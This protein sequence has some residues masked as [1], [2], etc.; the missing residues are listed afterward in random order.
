MGVYIKGMEMPK[1]GEL[2]CINIHP[3]GKVCINLDLECEKVGEA[4][5][6]PEHGRLI[7]ADALL[8]DLLFPSKQFEQGMR[9]LIGDAPT[10]IPAEETLKEATND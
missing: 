4:V 9:E 3:D 10:I 6:V 8:D 7:D 5:P 1:D 2:L